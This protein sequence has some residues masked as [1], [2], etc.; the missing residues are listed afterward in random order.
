M[1]L[2]SPATRSLQQPFS[3]TSYKNWQAL[4]IG[5]NRVLSPV[6]LPVSPPGQGKNFHY[7]GINLPQPP[8]EAFGTARGR[9]HLAQFALSS[10]QHTLPGPVRTAICKNFGRTV[11][12]Q[13]VESSPRRVSHGEPLCL[14]LRHEPSRIQL[15]LAR[16]HCEMELHRIPCECGLERKFAGA[17]ISGSSRAGSKR[18]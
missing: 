15:P 4:T 11:A 2:Y 18:N 6:R 7:H 9:G 8:W 16:A 3:A 12:H 17:A 14:L 10:P 5:L 13:R 1:G